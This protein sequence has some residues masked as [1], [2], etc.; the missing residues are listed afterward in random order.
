MA[1]LSLNDI[2]IVDVADIVI[3]AVLLYVLFLWFKRTRSAY[4]FMGVVIC[5]VAYV[6]AKFLKLELAASLMQGFFAVFLVGFVVIFQEDIRR[7]LEHI[8]RWSLAPTFKRKKSPDS[9]I[10]RA[11]L[12]AGAAFDFAREKVGALIVL[13]GRDSLAR[14]IHGGI[15]L[16]GILSAPLLKSIFDTHSA[17]HDGAV[18][19]H[20]GT[21]TQFGGQLPLSKN[22]E[23]L[24]GRGTRHA[25]ALGLSELADVLCIIV[26][27]ETG[28]VSVSRYGEIRRIEHPQELSQVL[29]DFGREIEP[30]QKSKGIGALLTRNMKEKLAAAFV[31]LILWFVFVHQSTIV[32]K[33]YVVPVEYAGLRAT[34]MVEDVDPRAVKVVL[35]GRRRD[36]H[37]VQTKD[38]ELVLKL[39]DLDETGIPAQ[40]SYE[41][42]V[43]A[44]DI[45][46]PADLTI[47]NIFPRNVRLRLGQK[48]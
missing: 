33:S 36:F 2:G 48:P 35:S 7:V 41:L 24:E 29:E 5:T 15:E 1:N 18:I 31:S 27:E 16:N 43:T 9:F 40:D 26:S 39:F 34:R 19:V 30:V 44:S 42:T 3:V 45:R 13:A 20:E 23:R 8:A 11:E 25:A 14:H 47:V 46:L 28:D 38:V 4:V 6:V 12:V 37:F 21:V 10:G 22:L 17:G 32:Y